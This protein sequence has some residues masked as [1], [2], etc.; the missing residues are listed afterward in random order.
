VVKSY[1]AV[2]IAAFRISSTAFITAGIL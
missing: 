1:M 2:F